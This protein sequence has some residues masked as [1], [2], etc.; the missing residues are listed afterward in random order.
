M[1]ESKQS[2]AYKNVNHYPKSVRDAEDVAKYHDI[3]SVH[4]AVINR[5]VETIWS[6]TACTVDLS[7]IPLTT[8]QVL[9]FFPNP[10]QI[11]LTGLYLVLDSKTIDPEQ[12][13]T[14]LSDFLVVLNT[15]VLDQHYDEDNDDVTFA[16]ITQ[17]SIL[18]SCRNL[19]KLVLL[20]HVML[21]SF[22]TIAH[23]KKLGEF[24]SLNCSDLCNFDGLGALTDLV[25]LDLRECNQLTS[26]QSLP[27]LPN[28]RHFGVWSGELND[29][30]NLALF[31]ALSVLVLDNLF[32]GKDGEQECELNMTRSQ[33]LEV[34]TI[35]KSSGFRGINLFAQCPTLKELDVSDC[36]HLAVLNVNMCSNLQVLTAQNC[37]SLKWIATRQCPALQAI[38]IKENQTIHS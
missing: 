15:L 26:F 21:D 12:E 22:K 38:H 35:T 9:D 31:P 33:T 14:L 5:L 11:N 16:H 1:A 18:S 37:P 4:T 27:L 3:A 7:D 6:G 20:H 24:K 13:L 10:N 2:S 23:C 17:G 8:S 32:F 34:L 19:T 28:L 36:K 30:P 29:L 25:T